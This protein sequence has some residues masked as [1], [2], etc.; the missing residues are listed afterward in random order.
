MKLLRT[1]DESFENLPGYDF[2]PSYVEVGSG[3]LRARMH[4]V[5]AGNGSR[6]ILLLHGQPSWSYLYR[7]VIRHLQAAESDL[8]IL[9]P[10]LIG[11][12][13]SD[14]PADISDYTYSRHMQ[15]LTDFIETLALKDIT[16]YVQDWGGLLGLRLAGQ[17]PELFSAITAAN[18]GLPTGHQTMPQVWHDF[19]RFCTEAKRLPIGRM[20]AQGCVRPMADDVKRAYAAPYPDDSYCAGVRAFPGLIPLS[21]ADPE[22]QINYAALKRLRKFERP[23]L[24]AFSDSDPITRGGDEILQRMIAGAAGQNHMTVVNAGHFLQEDAPDQVA[25]SILRVL[26]A[27]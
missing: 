2:A 15:W 27:V 17:R 25:S 21:P 3:Q 12:G 8:R 22:G 14:K 7:N 20:I 10:D 5:E 4:Y 6:T 13:R 11:F 9:A 19:K 18:T 24:T 16:M 1:A 23:F 26:K